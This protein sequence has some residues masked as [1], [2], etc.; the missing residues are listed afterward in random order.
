VNEAFCLFLTR[1]DPGR[2]P[3]PLSWLTTTL[4]RVCWG[5]ARGSR[6]RREQQ[7]FGQE[8]DRRGRSATHYPATCDRLGSSPGL[9]VQSR[10]HECA[11][12]GPEPPKRGFAA[13]WTTLPGILTG[14]AGFVGALAAV[15]AL[16]VAPGDS[17]DDGVSR[18]EWADKVDPLCSE[19]TDS[20]RQLSQPATNDVSAQADFI[21]QVS[22]IQR[23]VS[24]KVR[25]IEAPTEDQGNIDRMTALWDQSADAA[26]IMA[27][28]VLG[29]DAA[30]FQSAQQQV[31]AASS[32]GDSLATS[33]GATACAQTPTP[34]PATEVPEVQQTPEQTSAGASDSSSPGPG[35]PCSEGVSAGPATSCEFALNVAATYYQS[36]GASSIDVYSPVTERTYRMS[37]TSGSPHTCTGGNDASVYFP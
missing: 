16:F 8:L 7:V 26:D 5:R 10:E 29:G 18:A 22:R 13:F 21:R 6:A 24:G 11:M 32:E 19:A 28:A 36:G 9:G 1:F 2:F 25:A 4:K 31:V 37:C 23:G 14:I 35:T 3:E 30:T 17:G 33:L 12:A 20:L 27:I 15:L 34:T